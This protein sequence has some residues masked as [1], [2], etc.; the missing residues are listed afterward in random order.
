M[1]GASLSKNSIEI[2]K[3]VSGFSAS[4][5]QPRI[6]LKIKLKDGFSVSP[7]CLTI[8][9]K[10]ILIKENIDID[11]HRDCFVSQIISLVHSILKEKK[12]P[13]LFTPVVEK[14]TDYHLVI[15]PSI[16]NAH[17]S[18]I[19]TAIAI[20]EFFIKGKPEDNSIEKIRKQI[21]ELKQ[22]S[23]TRGINTLAMIEAAHILGIP[24]YR[25][26]NNIYQFGQGRRLHFFDSSCSDQTPALALQLSKNK[27]LCKTLLS[28]SGLPVA[29]GGLVQSE[30]HALRSAEKLGYPVV[31]KPSNMDQGK[32][33]FS[34]IDDEQALR[35]ALEHARSFSQK[36]MLERFIPGND[37]RI[38]TLNGKAYRIRKR[39]PGGVIG[40][41]V[42]TISMLLS[43]LNSDPRRA[44]A[45]QRTDL[46]RIALDQE[47]LYMLNRQGL[48]PDDIPELGQCVALRTTA[49]V[50]TGGITEAVPIE[51]A[52][53]ENLELA[54]RAVAVLN[55]DIAAVDLITPD[56]T[57]S[58]I[59]KGGAICEV[60]GV[61][62]FG[63]SDAPQHIMKAFFPEGGLIPAALVVGTISPEALRDLSAHFSNSGL[64]LGYADAHSTLWVGNKRMTSGCKST[65]S[66]GQALIAQRDVDAILL[67]ADEVL[68][69]SGVFTPRIKALI[70]ASTPADNLSA[71]LVSELLQMSDHI[72]TL[73]EGAQALKTFEYPAEKITPLANE[74]DLTRWMGRHFLD[75]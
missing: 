22:H 18:I 33:V 26:F 16:Q 73:P 42:S 28:R 63:A 72:L 50:S 67:Q 9:C 62:Q 65:Y 10:E 20:F 49:N 12:V 47:A 17:N 53:P 5:P 25:H 68:E 3:T 44:E 45:S 32:G 69:K 71:E 21:E 27:M 40:D 1:I 61:P 66:Q 48:T 2:F 39:T 15:I 35:T 4:F 46:V 13:L 64:N 30:E 24:F 36:I 37:Y 29:Q 54:E 14:H 7:E 70:M 52:H 43:Q 51:L 74:G 57:A 11:V 60:N 75:L 34:L 56:I 8:F 41:G 58:W 59:D 23:A 31:V 6:E 19:K 38:H 55:L